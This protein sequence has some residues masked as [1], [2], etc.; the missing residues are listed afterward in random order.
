[1]SLDVFVQ[2]F[3][4]GESA[5]GD[6]HEVRKA[7]ERFISD[8]GGTWARVTTGDGDAEVYGMDDLDSGLMFTNL[9]GRAVWDVVFETARA[10]GFVV[11]PVGCPVGVPD[12]RH[13]EHLPT[14][15]VDR[16]GVVVVS[17]GT[18]L[19]AVVQSA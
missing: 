4:R 14:S 6:G 13:L 5:R 17:S 12:E 2:G 11:M 3:R 1:M 7:L 10:G 9:S 15:L 8:S 16:A 18:D 19:L